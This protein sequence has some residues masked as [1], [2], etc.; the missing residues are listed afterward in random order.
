MIN[1]WLA[2]FG[3]NGQASN[4]VSRP[5]LEA[6]FKT[7]AADGRILAWDLCNE[8]FNNGREVYLAWLHESYVADLHRPQ[9][10]VISSAEYM[11]F[12]HMDGSLRAGHEVFN[13]YA[14]PR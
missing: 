11:A 1:Y 8:P 2:N 12:L 5:Y 10:G 6:L 4:Y 7:H 14:V 3:R 13:R 9:Y